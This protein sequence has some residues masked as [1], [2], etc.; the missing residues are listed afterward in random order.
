MAVIC[1]LE[2]TSHQQFKLNFSRHDYII[3]NEDLSTWISVGK[4]DEMLRLEWEESGSS[5]VVKTLPGEPMCTFAPHTAALWE[6][7]FAENR[8]RQ[9][10]SRL[11]WFLLSLWPQDLMP[12]LLICDGGC[13]SISS[14]QNPFSLTQRDIMTRT[15]RTRIRRDGGN[16]TLDI[17]VIET[18]SSEDGT[19]Q[20]WAAVV[21][22]SGE[23]QRYTCYVDHEGLTEPFTLRWEPPQPSVPIMTIV[24]DLVLGAVLMGAVVT[25]LIWKRRT[26][27]VK[28]IKQLD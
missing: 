26:K 12:F 23:E 16:Q 27:G 15:R 14:E 4:A 9:L 18:R 19:F 1:C 10:D 25:F 2:C 7:D 17:E 5:Q 11:Y 3:L 20:K 21:E 8:I 22:P 24:T 28:R 6:G 13:V